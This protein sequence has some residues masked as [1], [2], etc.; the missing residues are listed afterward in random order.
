MTGIDK[1]V[2]KM[3]EAPTGIKFADLCKVCGSYFGEPRHDSTSHKIYKTP[4][5]GNPR[6]N[7]QN[8]KG[9]AKAYQV[10]QVLLAIDKLERRS[11]C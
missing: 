9:K 6:I 8:D 10:K 1:I 4:W 2:S 7:I 11:S 5:K 3:K